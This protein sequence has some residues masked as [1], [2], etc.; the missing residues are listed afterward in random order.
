[1]A[2]FAARRQTVTRAPDHG[3]MMSNRGVVML[4]DCRGLPL[5]TSSQEAAAAFDHAMDGY[6][7]NR[8]DLPARVDALLK[9][10]P[11]FGLA[12][13][14]RGYFLMAGF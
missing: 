10:D 3:M 11:D 7:R 6:L 13:T 8:A 14:M 12:H 2:A 4:S 5:S 9:A 1:M